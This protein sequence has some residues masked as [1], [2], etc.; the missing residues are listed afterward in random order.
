MRRR[1][2]THRYFEQVAGL[3]KEMREEAQGGASYITPLC[4]A[5][6]AEA[7]LVELGCGSGALL[8]QLLPR[9]GKTIGVDYS[10]SM[11]E[12]AG[13]SLA[14]FAAQLELR[15]GTLEHLP[16]A[17]A[18]VDAALAYM[19]LHH[20][21]APQQAL[22]DAGRVLRPGGRLIVVDFVQHHNELMRE[23]YADQWLGFEAGQFTSWLAAAGLRPVSRQLLGDNQQVFLS[24]AERI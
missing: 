22:Q 16:L 18:S 24:I 21:A 2:Q 19:V 20:V 4:E 9:R 13:R 6:P 23:R 3:W 7:T 12:E 1:D 14:R 11:L 17:D 15:L 5:I 8:E 10:Q